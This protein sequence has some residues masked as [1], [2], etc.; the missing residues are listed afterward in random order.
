MF[1]SFPIIPDLVEV[2][3]QQ[4]DYGAISISKHGHLESKYDEQII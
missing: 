3:E 1:M 4:R 2:E